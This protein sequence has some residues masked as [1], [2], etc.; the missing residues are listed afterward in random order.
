MIPLMHFLF[1]LSNGSFLI[2]GEG[3]LYIENTSLLSI[4]RD[5]PGYDISSLVMTP[6]FKLRRSL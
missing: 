3:A 6:T 5:N 1:M 4:R 2:K